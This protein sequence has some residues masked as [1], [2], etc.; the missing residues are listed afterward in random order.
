MSESDYD[1]YSG[2]GGSSGGFRD[3]ASKKPYDEYDAGD[4]DVAAARR[5][6]SI[7]TKTPTSATGLRRSSTLPSASISPPKAKEPEVDLLGMDDDAFTSVVPPTTNK[8]LPAVISQP[9]LDG[10]SFSARNH[11]CHT[12]T[13]SLAGDDDFDDFQTAPTSPGVVNTGFLGAAPAPPVLSAPLIAQATS[14]PPMQ[15]QS[16]MQPT[17]LF[18]SGGFG[19]SAATPAATTMVANRPNYMAATPMGMGQMQP[20][21]FPSQSALTPSHSRT[22]SMPGLMS[23]NMSRSGST[24]AVKPA[25]AK[26]NFD[27]LWSMSLGSTSTATKPAAGAAPSKSIKDLEKEKPQAGI[28]GAAQQSRPPMGAGF[29]SFGS[30]APP[31]SSS[32][33]GNGLDDLLL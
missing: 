20:S 10:A 33:A 15:P 25:A 9:A 11:L 19:V 4:D 3:Q 6:N 8:A 26:S 7:S 17:N 5:S 31:A 14:L 21:I 28:W 30:A 29:G 1:S 16:T 27:D 32:S 18:A 23:N 13:R 24:S 22:G 12:L 2:G